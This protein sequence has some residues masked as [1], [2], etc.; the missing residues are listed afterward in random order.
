MRT[1][2]LRSLTPYVYI[3]ERTIAVYCTEHLAYNTGVILALLNTNQM[4]L[5]DWSISL[6]DARKDFVKLQSNEFK[7]TLQLEGYLCS[8]QMIK[9]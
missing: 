6:S 1:H 3:E 8:L 5:L 9:L 4:K 2:K 7:T